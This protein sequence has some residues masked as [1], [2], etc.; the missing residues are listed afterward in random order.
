LDYFQERKLLKAAAAVD[1]IEAKGT[2]V[3]NE[4]LQA[5]AGTLGFEAP[6]L[7]NERKEDPR[8]LDKRV[9]CL[10]ETISAE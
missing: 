2:P 9:L 7:Q 1:T 4:L 10:E 6:L 3:L 5:K 8:G